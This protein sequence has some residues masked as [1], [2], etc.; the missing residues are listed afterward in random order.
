MHAGGIKGGSSEVRADCCTG[1]N[2]R[3]GKANSGFG[4]GH[5]GNKYAAQEIVGKTKVLNTFHYN[6]ASS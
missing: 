4:F 2:E 1:K 5:G 6:L 3:S